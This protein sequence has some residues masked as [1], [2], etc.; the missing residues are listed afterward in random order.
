MRIRLSMVGGVLALLLVAQVPTTSQERVHQLGK[1]KVLTIKV[2]PEV[3]KTISS[4]KA[5]N[6]ELLQSSITYRQ[7]TPL[8]KLRDGKQVALLPVEVEPMPSPRERERAKMQIAQLA[9]YK[10]YI[11]HATLD[12]RIVVRLIGSTID[13]RC[14]QTAI[15]DQLDRNTC[16]AFASVA[17]IEAFERRNK[18]RDLDL[19]EQHTYHITMVD[20]SSTCRQ[21]PGAYTYMLAQYLT[22]SKNSTETQ[23]PYTDWL[24]LPTNDSTHVP[25]ACS[26]VGTYGFTD[27]QVVLGTDWGGPAD[28]NANNPEYLESLLTAGYD[29]VYGMYVAGTDWS[30]GTAETGIID[31]QNYGGSPAE[32]YGGHAMLLV[33][34]VRGGSIYGVRARYFIFKNSWNT[35]RGHE[36]YFYIS[37]DYIRTYGKYGYIIKSVAD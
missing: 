31:V 1:I 14:C 16:T 7:S 21:D 6:L 5:L 12:P 8:L 23:F 25:A 9:P 29:M 20:T 4:K 30:D 33:G 10:Q 24:S 27:T 22:N 17:G 35:T 11:Q 28:Q 19:S 34:F 15:R 26:N 36:G 37:Y 3:A 2:P 13:H 32:P 18:N